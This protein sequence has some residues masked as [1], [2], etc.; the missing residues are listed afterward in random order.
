MKK[1][2]QT[3][4]ETSY[5]GKIAKCKSCHNDRWFEGLKCECGEQGY[6]YEEVKN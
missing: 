3:K 2:T 6:Y 5:F 1:T 4:R